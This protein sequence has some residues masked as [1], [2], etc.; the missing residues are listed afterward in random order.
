[1][2]MTRKH[3]T[4]DA[5]LAGRAD[6]VAQHLTGKSRS[7]IRGL[8]DHGCVALNGERCTDI[9]AKV[10]NG[11]AF[12]VNY[13]LHTRY[14]EREREWEDDAFKLVFED[15]HLIVVDKAAGALTVPAN[16]GETDSVMHAI[17]RYLSHRGTR[18]RAQPVH[19][20][21]RG[22]SGLL[23]FGKNREI[24][25]ELQKQF[26]DRMA[27]REY[28]A[29][30]N[31]HLPH[32]T[33]TFESYITT[34]LSLQQYSTTKPGEGQLAITHYRAVDV[35]RGA[36]FVRVWLETGRRNQIR[37]HFAE[38][39]FPV[40]GDPR[41]RPDGSAHPHWRV[42]R[43]ALHA[44]VLGLRHPVTGQ[45]LRFE[46]PMPAPMKSFLGGEKA[47]AARKPGRR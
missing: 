46:A 42:K 44:A 37:V 40:L 9:G 16:S 28:M 22:A 47:P 17:T 6:K 45:P 26:E 4:V 18:D 21:D 35:A 25:A 30:V 24:A 20:L 15:K 32:E 11:D 31:G 8:F 10:R 2:A 41:Y 36:T 39:G 14:H 29:I 13:D 1:M 7:E 34:S 19:R 3:V 38:A 23:I 33:G 43:L 12:E 27:E 5:A